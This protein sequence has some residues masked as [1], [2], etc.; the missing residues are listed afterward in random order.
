MDFSRN[1]AEERGTVMDVLRF[2]PSIC[3]N[4]YK[5]V[6]HCPVKSIRVHKGKPQIVSSDCI[7][8][9]SCVAVCP[10]RAKEDISQVPSIQ[11]L[12]AEGRQVVASVDSTYL[13]Y[14]D[15]DTFQ[16][17]RGALM[18]LGFSDAYETAEGAQM[19]QRQLEILASQAEG[20]PIITSG[21]PS[22]VLYAEKH[23]PE[24]LPY[25]APV[26]SP[27][28]A[29]AQ[30]LRQRC[31]GAAVVYIGPCVSRKEETKSFESVG[32]DYAITLTEL[33]QWM[34][35]AGVTIDRDLPQDEPKASHGYVVTGGTMDGMTRLLGLDYLF[36]D[37]LDDCIKVLK[38]V[39]NGGLKGCFIE[40][41]ACHGNCIGGMVFNHKRNNLLESRRKVESVS[42]Y[43]GGDYDISERI[44]M[45]RAMEDHRIHPLEIPSE[46]I[47][48]GILRKMGKF[49]PED[50][51]NCGLCG[52]RTCREK[53]IAEYAGRAELT[54]CVPYMIKK[55][56]TYSEKIINVSPEGIITVGKDLKVQQI[57]AAACRI[58]GI[59]D[60]ADIVGYPVSRIMDEYDF[61]KLMGM[62]E[63]QYT[64]RVYLA[65]YNVYLER[66][67]ICDPER[68][69]YTCIMRDVTQSRQRREQVQKTKLHAAEL[70]D[71]I[72]DNQLRIVHQIA[73]LL[74][75][76]AAET[77]VAV[78]DLKQAIL[79]DEDEDD[80]EENDG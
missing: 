39:V 49:N 52:Y 40:M 33:E 20:K 14:F 37:G 3:I 79:L 53:A 71:V 74:G 68:T 35:S 66:I 38:S 28:Q 46:S 56:E 45:Y 19:V 12:L 29:H 42:L 27:A 7:L 11:R 65:E 9:G 73:S 6:R 80:E 23:Y 1:P 8:C 47:I 13:P 21:C 69:L 51:L 41:A 77:K 43:N 59:K 5:C 2:N 31:P 10:R 30:A 25:L 54:M 26:L 70:A 34:H 60:T 57:N 75:E 17:L 55:A 22:I 64:D 24:V 48:T 36:V 32:A 78:H 63:T 16:G 76:T 4:C 50:Q 72:I 61:V 44:D 67:F 15:V 18:E 58:F 62:E